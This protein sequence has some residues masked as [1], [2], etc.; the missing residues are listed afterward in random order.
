MQGVRGEGRWKN[1]EARAADARGDESKDYLLVNH[2]LSGRCRSGRVE[3][4]IMSRRDC[5][6]A[7]LETRPAGPPE[8]SPPGHGNGPP[9]GRWL[10]LRTQENC[11][12]L[13]LD[14]ALFAAGLPERR[15]CARCTRFRRDAFSSRYGGSL[16]L[17]NSAGIGGEA[18]ILFDE[19]WTVGVRFAGLRLESLG[20]VA[21]FRFRWFVEKG[22]RFLF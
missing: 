21:R 12:G 5:L 2:L 15:V 11:S 19:F 16:I 3:C 10:L 4:P 22:V 8:A 13:S 14:A 17:F 1:R 6:S 7:A 20:R 9:P 18:R